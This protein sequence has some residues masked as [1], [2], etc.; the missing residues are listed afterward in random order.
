MNYVEIYDA[1]M[2]GKKT[3]LLIVSFVCM[4]LYGHHEGLDFDGFTESLNSLGQLLTDGYSQCVILLGLLK[5]F[6]RKAQDAE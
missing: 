3:Y 5:A 2:K 4:A 1:F 6:N